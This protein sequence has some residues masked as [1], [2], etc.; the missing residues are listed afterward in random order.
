MA[1][2]TDTTL[3]DSFTYSVSD[4]DASTSATVDITVNVGS[5]DSGFG[6]Q[7][8]TII[9][10]ESNNSRSTAQVISR[11][12]FGIAPNT[13]VG[14]DSQPWVSIDAQVAYNYDWDWYAFEVQEDE[15]LTLDI[16]YGMGLGA[17]S[18]DTVMYLYQGDSYYS[19]AYNDDSS[20]YAG[21]GGSANNYWGYGDSFIET[22]ELSEG[23][24]Y[25]AVRNFGWGS[26]H[27]Y[28]T[29]DYVLNVSIDDS[30]AIPPAPDFVI[31]GSDGNDIL[32]GASGDDELTGGAGN[33]VLFGGSGTDTAVFSGD[34]RDYRYAIDGLSGALVVADQSGDGG[35]DALSGIE[36][37]QFADVLAMIADANYDSFDVNDTRT[38][39]ADITVSDEMHVS[40]DGAF[41]IAPAGSV[42]VGEDLTI[43]N[44]ASFTNFGSV[45][46]DDELLM[47]DDASFTNYGDLTVDDDELLMDDRAS[48]TNYGLVEIG[49]ED[50]TMYDDASFTNYGTL[51]IDDDDL[52]I[53][54]DASFTNYG[55]VE[56]EDDLKVYDD[57]S[58]INYGTVDVDDDLE[59]QNWGEGSATFD[60]YGA[61]VT[62]DDLE[63]GAW[64]EGG[65]SDA[66]ASFVN[67]AAGT[68]T[69]GED[70]EIDAYDDLS[71]TFDNYGWIDVDDSLDVYSDYYGDYG[72]DARFT[73]YAGATLLVGEDIDITAYDNV[74]DGSATLENYG[75]I[76][77][78]GGLFTESNGGDATFT[79]YAGATLLVDGDV[80]FADGDNAD[81]ARLENLLGGTITVGGALELYGG[82]VLD[83]L[84]E[85][86]VDDNVDVERDLTNAGILTVGED[87]YL[88]NGDLTNDGTLTAGWYVQAWGNVLNS[89]TL[90]TGVGPY[91]ANEGGELWVDGVLANDSTGVIEVGSYIE[92]WGVDYGP[93]DLGGPGERDL[94]EVIPGMPVLANAGSIT[95][96]DD[97]DVWGDVANAAGALL[98]MG[99]DISIYEGEVGSKGDLY[100]AGTIIA[101]DDILVANGEVWNDG[102]ITAGGSFVVDNDNLNNAGTVTAGGYVEVWGNLYTEGGSTITA[103]AT[104]TNPIDNY[105]FVYGNLDNQGSI[106]AGGAFGVFGSVYSA[107]EITV[108]DQAAFGEGATL[109]DS[110]ELNLTLGGAGFLESEFGM[111][112][113]LFVEGGLQMDGVLNLSW[114]GEQ[115]LEYGGG[116]YDVIDWGTGWSEGF[117]DQIDG[118]YQADLGEN[119]SLFDAT[120]DDAGMYVT[121]YEVTAATLLGGAEDDVL[122][123]GDTA[124]VLVG[125]AGEDL[126][127]GGGGGDVFTFDAASGNDVVLDFGI[128]DSLVF[129][130]FDALLGD[131]VNWLY[132]GET[133]ETTIIGA[134]DSGESVEVT[135]RAQDGS[136]YTVTQDGDDV[137][138]KIDDGSSQPG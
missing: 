44:D 9:E 99:G 120:F 77:V 13:D 71:A 49:E 89:G 16:D 128:D 37:A 23:T 130:D 127:F 22:G 118:L 105:M 69:V 10:V 93:P 85:I 42:D 30:S 97:L 35:A 121:A 4:G 43:E 81:Q 18:V 131:S 74:G 115:T 111:E 95:A 88:D 132:N 14:D 134:K 119:G 100:N 53:Y 83:N 67:Y 38:N 52:E 61:I 58:F 108:G 56:V 92:I 24:Y 47:Y 1:A 63:V 48:F 72:G 101:G 39:F 116:G 57:A 106:D 124:D 136:G 27:S 78:E 104:E 87:V 20:Q 90:N 5:G 45:Y 80:Q 98:D 135:L 112:A 66:S 51:D 133:H 79:N 109:T 138:V 36:L 76:D 86:T 55:L 17:D 123:G 84:G 113:A 137:V 11:S 129:E 26:G 107:G 117:F 126:L 41:T 29:G 46:V 68:I 60:N 31:A 103:G 12:D 54:D 34:I 110:S 33:D 75:L 114:G 94:G 96:A 65:S 3:S 2:D 25:A 6:I 82:A 59:V 62:S 122:A 70:L 32:I 102:S 40:G 21:G 91:A 8:Q 15:R 50:L 125:G 28:S 7:P 19:Y 64:G 73:N